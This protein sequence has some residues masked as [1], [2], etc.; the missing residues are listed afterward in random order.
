MNSQN[1]RQGV[2]LIVTIVER[3]AGRAVQKLYAKNGVEMHFQCAGRGT[4]SSEVL[5]LLGFGTPERDILLS[6]AGA[7]AANAL[8]YELCHE[9]HR[10]ARAKGIV[11]SAP[12]TAMNNLAAAVLAGTAP[13]RNGGKEMQSEKRYSL[14]LAAVNQGCTE[15]VMK[16]ARAAGARGGTVIRTR[17]TGLESAEAFHGITLQSEKE[18]IAIVAENEARGAILEAVN[19]QHGLRSEAEAVLCSLALEQYFPL[20]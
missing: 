18:L 4:A 15:M 3:G 11:F 12:L 9:Q 5:D 17:W 20:G 13:P 1:A 2:T 6:L 19:A 10:A 8:L 14:I 16:T 7:P